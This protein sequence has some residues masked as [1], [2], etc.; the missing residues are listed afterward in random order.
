VLPQVRRDQDA[1]LGVHGALDRPRHQHAAHRLHLGL[2]LRLALEERLDGLPATVGVETECLAVDE[3]REDRR[4]LVVGLEFHP[5]YLRDGYAPLGVENVVDV[6]SC[7][8]VG[9]VALSPPLW[10]MFCHPS[11]LV[12][13]C[14][15]V[16]TRAPDRAQA[17]NA[18]TLRFF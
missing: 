18:G 11:P 9:L 13:T 6:P 5:V 8:R 17:E 1:A 4:S 15:T 10:G 7:H 3:R 14:T 2:D 16:V 12:P